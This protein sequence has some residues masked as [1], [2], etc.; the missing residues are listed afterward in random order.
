MFNSHS[1]LIVTG[2]SILWCTSFVKV[3]SSFSLVL[4]QHYQITTKTYGM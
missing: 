4:A 1:T 2:Y 3:L